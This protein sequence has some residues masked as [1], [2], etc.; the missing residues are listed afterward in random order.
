MTD[1]SEPAKEPYE[2]GDRVQVRLADEDASTTVRRRLRSQ[3]RCANDRLRETGYEFRYP[4]F[5][6]GYRAAIDAFVDEEK[7]GDS[8]G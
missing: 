1:D 2:V 4:T 6:E 5:R 8:A 7:S 3:K